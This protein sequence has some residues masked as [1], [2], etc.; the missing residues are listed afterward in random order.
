MNMSEKKSAQ[1]IAIDSRKP[2][3][4]DDP[5]T[6]KPSRSGYRMAGYCFLAGADVQSEVVI[7]P[8]IFPVP[9]A[10]EWLV[11]L[12]NVR[13]NIVPVFDLWKFL[14]TQTPQREMLTVLVLDLGET[15]AGLVIDNL[16]TP[17]PLDSQA[18]ATQPPAPALQPFL[19]LGLHAFDCEWWEFDHQKFLACLSEVDSR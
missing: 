16:P 12:A 2:R 9:K 8:A 10:P 7:S 3:S 17:V 13:G 15:A 5:V 19:G 14:R 6:L 18:V 4:S 1:I 11:G